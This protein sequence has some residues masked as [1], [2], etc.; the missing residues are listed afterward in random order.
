VV[1]VAVDRG[2][3]DVVVANGDTQLQRGDE[4]IAMIRR[5]MRRD[6]CTALVG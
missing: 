6:V 4:V 1:I 3:G 5:T 2:N